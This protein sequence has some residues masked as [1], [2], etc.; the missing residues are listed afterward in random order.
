MP[1]RFKIGDRVEGKLAAIRHFSGRILEIIPIAVANRLKVR[2][3]HG[4]VESYSSKAL[5]F[6]AMALPLDLMNNLPR[7]A[8]AVTIP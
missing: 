2:W 7:N 1:R 3:D 4:L 5:L 8:L 6:P